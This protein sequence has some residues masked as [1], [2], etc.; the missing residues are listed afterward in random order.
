MVG[1]MPYLGAHNM[2]K[3]MKITRS[4]WCYL[5]TS[6]C[7][8]Y[9]RARLELNGRT[10]T[11]QKNGKDLPRMKT[12]SPITSLKRD[13]WWPSLRQD[14]EQYVKGCAICQENKINTRPLKPAMIPITH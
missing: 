8:Q 1:Q 4:L 11:T 7:P 12:M 3:A 10:P 5:N 6:S 14:I 9:K 13:F 2:T